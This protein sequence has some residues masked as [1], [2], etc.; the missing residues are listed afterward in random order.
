MSL[1]IHPQLPLG[2]EAN[3]R[4]NFDSFVA[5]DNAQAAGI[6]RQCALGQGEQQIFLWSAPGLGKSHLLQA[7]CQLA[8]RQ[9]RAVCYLTAQQML[10]QPVEMFE[11]LEQLQLICLDDLEQWLSDASWQQALFNLI[12]RIRESGH[13][14]IMASAT[15]PDASQI[16]LPDL[17]SRLCWGPVF[18]LKPLA[19]ADKYLAMKI[20]ARQSGL[21]LPKNVADYLLH[22]YP[23]DLNDLFERLAVLDKAA[24]S[25]K[26]PLTIPLIKTVFPENTKVSD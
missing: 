19:D 23:R 3:E 9:Q 25:V 10:H 8:A 13:S 11:G 7:C 20:R 21:E 6:V 4:F 17:R 24:M 26:R 18:Q 14:L 1:L 5:G 22:R 12:N 16:E 15:S 2:L